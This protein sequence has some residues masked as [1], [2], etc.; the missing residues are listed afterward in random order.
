MQATFSILTNSI[1]SHIATVSDYD[2]MVI[3][4]EETPLA[5]GLTRTNYFAATLVTIALIVLVIA[6]AIW[7]V[8]R[9][10]YKARLLELRHRLGDDSGVVPFSIRAMKDAIAECEAELVA[11]FI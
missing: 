2:L 1:L 11:P 4:D 10:E 9:R 5:A 3:E 8:K 6:I 7:Y